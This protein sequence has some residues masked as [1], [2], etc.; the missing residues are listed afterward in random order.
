MADNVGGNLESKASSSGYQA[1]VGASIVGGAFLVIVICL[2]GF[3]FFQVKV[4]DEQR[5]LKLEAMKKELASRPNDEQFL[6]Q[7]RELDLKIRKDTI[8][9]RLFLQKGAFLAIGGL[10]VFFA[11]L[12][13][14]SLYKQKLPDPQ[15]S[16]D[17]RNQQVQQAIQ[18]RLAVTIALVILAAVSI[19]LAFSETTEFEIVVEV[20][21]IPKQMPEVPFPTMDQVNANW[22]SFRGPGGS[23]ISAY[24]N[25]PDKW[26]GQSGEGI[27]WKSKI[28]L[29]SHNS[30]IVWED[31]IFITGADETRRQ[32]YCYDAS[33]GKLLWTADAGT[34]IGNSFELDIMEDTGYAA[35]TAVTDGRRVCAL[36]ANG[37][38]S[39]FDYEGKKLWARN[40][41]EPD[42]VYGY[43]SSLAM[44]ENLVLVQYDQ[45]DGTDGKSKMIA[46]DWLNGKIVWQTPRD[47]PN[48]WTSPIVAKVGSDYQIITCGSPWVIAYDPKDGRELWRAD[49]LGGDVAPSPIYADGKV[50]AIEPYN[51]MVA[52]KAE[53]ASGDVTET[54]IDWAAEDDIPDICSPVSNGE[55]VILLTTDGWL[56]CY[57]VKDGSSVWTQE[58]KGTFQASCSIVADKLYILSTKGVMII[59]KIGAEYVELG[60]SELKEECYASPAFADGRIY[61]RGVEHL[62]CIGSAK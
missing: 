7:I 35:N 9:R 41:G 11:G 29:V 52:I 6:Q 37:D 58:L 54:N 36:F 59:A 23:G 57:N 8:R 17:E 25:V 28:E 34:P 40:L 31:R 30:P 45:G 43:A 13:I 3:T 39:C 60:R 46:L 44:Y 49:C 4:T 26:D 22:G 15:I 21:T 50:L 38:I 2:L 56:S 1:A 47:V 62:Y 61:I 18:T 48:S 10:V 20:D 33:S 53:G 16:I 19:F 24:T 55:F 51:Q 12:K 42:S 32:V 27:L 14:A 5:A